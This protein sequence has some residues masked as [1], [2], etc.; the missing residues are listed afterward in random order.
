MNADNSSF[1]M[2][3]HLRARSLLS[4]H[5]RFLYYIGTRRCEKLKIWSPNI[6]VRLVFVAY[7]Q[8]SRYRRRV[9]Y[10]ARTTYIFTYRVYTNTRRKYD[11]GL[12]T[13][14]GY[15]A[16]FTTTSNCIFRREYTTVIIL[17]LDASPGKR[18]GP[19][20]C[21]GFA[22]GGGNGYADVNPGQKPAIL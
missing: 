13:K 17:E 22:S 6:L 15:G 1:N 20:W 8:Q 12:S 5:V 11:S 14:T 18:D 16:R 19:G 7:A 3:F 9:H 10:P 21:L 4:K 2:R